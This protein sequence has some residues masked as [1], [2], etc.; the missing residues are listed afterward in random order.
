MAEVNWRTINIDALDPE[1]PANFDV[2]TLVP[3]Q[4][5]V[6]AAEIQSVGQQCRQ[7]LRGGDSEGALTGAL[8]M[9]PYGGDANVKV[10]TIRARNA[11]EERASAAGRAGAYSHETCLLTSLLGRPPGHRRRDPP[12]HQAGGYDTYVKAHVWSTRGSGAA[13]H[14]NEVSL[15]GH[16]GRSLQQGTEKHKFAAADRWILANI[17]SDTDG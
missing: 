17:E 10:F 9:A 7:L 1:S 5:A 14:V 4:P 8:Q 16:V 13:G 12:E 2:S 15:Q 3:P 6:S 11:A